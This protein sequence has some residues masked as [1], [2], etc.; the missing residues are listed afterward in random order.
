MHRDGLLDSHIRVLLCRVEGFEFGVKAIE[1]H[2]NAGTGRQLVGLRC[3]WG[4]RH[5]LLRVE[6]TSNLVL[7]AG[8]ELSD[9]GPDHVKFLALGLRH[10][11][12]K[13]IKFA[14]SLLQLLTNL[15]HDV[16]EV[17]ANMGE[18]YTGQLSC[19]VFTTEVARGHC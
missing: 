10:G 11:L 8:Y 12:T 17:V 16:W 7:V 5:T 14:L 9:H 6:L 3:P 19:E 4:C 18:Q 15:V 13:V 2:L 1:L